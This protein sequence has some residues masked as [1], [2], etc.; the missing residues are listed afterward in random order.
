MLAHE[1]VNR[2]NL[3]TEIVILH[4]CFVSIFGGGQYLGPP[5]LKSTEGMLATLHSS[6][7]LTLILLNLC[8]AAFLMTVLLQVLLCSSSRKL[9]RSSSKKLRS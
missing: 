7:H 1:D 8:V 5:I 4:F 2:S 9:S 6:D 3:L